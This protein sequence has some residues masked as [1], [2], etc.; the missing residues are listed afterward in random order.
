MAYQYTDYSGYGNETDEETRKRRAL[1]MA[2]LSTDSSIG[3]IAGNMLTNRLDQAQTNISN[4]GQILTNPEEELKKRMGIQP[5]M[6]SV[7]TEQEVAQQAQPFEQQ[8]QQYKPVAPSPLDT[9]SIVPPTLPS[10]GPISANEPLPNIGQP[11][12]PGPATNV[13]GPAV[14]QQPPAQPVVAQPVVAPWV[15]A[16]N[17]AGNDFNKLLD[18]AAKHPESRDFI[19]S[20]LETAFANKTKEDQANQLFKDAASGDLKAQ[21][22]IFQLIKPET[23]KPKEEVTVNDYVK[24]YMY[25]RLGLD[26]L[27]RDVQNKIIGK[28]TK[29]GQVTVGGTNW[30][31]ETDPSGQIVRA[32]DDEGNYA[33]EATLNKLRA[34]GQKF[35]TQSFSTTGGSITI[36][37]GQPDAGEEYRTVFNS[38]TGKFENTIITGKN[39]GKPYT[40]PAGLEKRVGTNA[41]VALNDAYIKYQTAPSTAAATEMAK[42]A[43]LLSPQDY[44]NTLQLIQR[45]TPQIYE[46]IKNTLPAGIGQGGAI[47]AGQNVAPAVAGD[48]AAIARLDRDIQSVDREIAR[49]NAT[50]GLDPTRRQQSLQ[51]LND[52]RAKLMATRQSMGTQPTTTTAPVTTTTAPTS[53]VPAGQGGGLLKRTEEVKTNVGVAGKRSESFNKILDEEVRPQAQA[54]DTVSSVRKQQFAIFDRPGIDSNKLFGLYNAAQENPSD[55]KLSIVRDIFGGVFKPEAEV[56]Q[57]LALLNLSPQEKSALIEYNIANQRI[58]AATLKQSAGPGSVSDAE[59][60]ANRE[61]NVDPTKVP[62]L[63]AYNAMAQSQFSGDMARYKADWAES[64]PATNAL[65]LDKAWR[66]ETQALSQI[67]GDIAKQRAQYIADNGATTAAVREGYKLYPIPEYDPNTGQWK[68]IKPLSNFKR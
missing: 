41:A 47:P 55:Q 26:D 24:A 9:R 53:V 30:A 64:Y 16:A 58:N 45:T 46:Q 8:L 50:P 13:A 44:S 12:T 28:D 42:T 7:P 68:K 62:A 32:R 18:V 52:E 38:T 6:P 2:G 37:A 51:V 3:D 57:R 31:V 61:S 1:M 15:T 25:K 17:N 27:A 40:G 19:Q 4:A 11:P 65:Q 21:N 20:K 54:G 29:F 49:A 23:G 14:V 59:Q 56:S 67:Y 10:K 34:A 60:K 66:K 33:T 22:K 39:A 35:G 36:P 63:G 48:A 43:A 5:V